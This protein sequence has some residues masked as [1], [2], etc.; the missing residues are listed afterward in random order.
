MSRTLVLVRHAKAAWPDHVADHDRPLAPR[1]RRD[2][3]AIGQWLA[4]HDV[5]ARTAVVSSARRTIETYELVAAAWPE[6]PEAVVTDDV[7][8][9]GAGDLLDVVRGLRESITGA[10]VVGHNP[11]IGTLAGVLDDGS[12]EV[13]GRERM[14]REFPTSAVA[15]L[16]VEGR[17]AEVDPGTARLIAFAVPRG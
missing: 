14:H 6:A 12:G 9:A 8:A 7:Y 3:P 15:V 1:G 11:G 5:A 10:V 16:E 4:A 17:W 2:A 13:D